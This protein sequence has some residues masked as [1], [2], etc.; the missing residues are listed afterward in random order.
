M[1]VT[2]LILSSPFNTILFT[3]LVSTGG[4][5]NNRE[6]NKISWVSLLSNV[7]LALSQVCLFAGALSFSVGISIRKECF[8]N[9]DHR[10]NP[11]MGAPILLI[12]SAKISFPNFLVIKGTSPFS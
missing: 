1:V 5:N 6:E 8:R 9:P 7:N 11:L 2:R 10:I 4:T 12:L 3:R